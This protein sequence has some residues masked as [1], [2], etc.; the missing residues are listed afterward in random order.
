MFFENIML[1]LSS[2]RSNMMR[3]ILTMLGI[4]IGIGA[5]ICIDTLG[6]SLTKS[7]ADTME[8]AGGS[9]I[10]LGLQQKDTER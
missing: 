4:I 2:L 3:T 9:T 5:V 8:T 10:Y 6:N 1:A 7:V